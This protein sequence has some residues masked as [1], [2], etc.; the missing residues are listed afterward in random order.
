MIPTPFRVL[1]RLREG[2]PPRP[3]EVRAAVAGAADGSW[4]DAQLGAFLMAVAIHGLDAAAVRE[5][6]LAMLDSGER[7]DLAAD[8]P[9]LT[10]KHSTGGVADTVSLVLG[11]LLAACDVPVV[12]VTGRGLGH[13][14]GTTDKLEAIPGLTLEHERP[15]VA[16]LLARHRLAILTST[17]ALAPA[18]R[19]LYALR[20][21]TATIRSI[22]LITGSILS[23]KLATGAA[24]LVFDV[25]TGN[26]AF[27]TDPAQARRLSEKLVETCR[28]LGRAASALLTDMSQPLG[29]WAGHTAELLA[30]FDALEGRGEPDLMAVTSALAVEMAALVGRPVGEAELEDAIAS[31]RAREVFVRWAE[32]Q[33]GDPRWLASPRFELAPVETAIEAP[34]AGVLARVDTRQLGLLLAEAGGGRLGPEPID[35]GVAL[36]TRARLG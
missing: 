9:T 25:K 21:Q 19:R 28:G 17:P 24:G 23:K 5:L 22:P 6:T 14:M 16:R 35:F 36:R 3:D 15:A 8:L 18:D 27:L 2:R 29:E 11:P 10:D 12:M 32:A 13:T 20:D 34:R 1:D 26:G 30:T 4:S 33:G 31:G 7:W